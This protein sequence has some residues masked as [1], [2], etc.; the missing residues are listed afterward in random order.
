MN[1]EELYLLQESIDSSRYKVLGNFQ[2]PI[3][4]KKTGINLKSIGD[5]FDTHNKET[6]E[7]KDQVITGFK[8]HLASHGLETHKVLLDYDTPSDTDWHKDDVPVDRDVVVWANKNPTHV[9]GFINKKWQDA[10]FNHG[11]MIQFDD[12]E[13]THRAP[14]KRKQKNRLFFRADVDRTL[15]PIKESFKDFLCRK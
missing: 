10:K 13:V 1:L 3:P 2:V 5:L 11:D 7:Y 6:R 9:H 12:R 14:S 8:K 15:D 4:K